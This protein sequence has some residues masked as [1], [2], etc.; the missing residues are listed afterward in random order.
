MYEVS[1]ENH[2]GEKIDLSASSSYD[3]LKID[4]LSP[5]PAT[6]NFSTMANFDGGKFN[7]GQ[8]QTRNIVFTIKI[9]PD[10]EENRI[11]L[12]KYFPS[13][14]SVRIYYRNDRRDVYID[15]IVEAVEIDPFSINETAQISIICPD[16]YW[17]ESTESRLNFSNVINLFEFPFSIP[18][19]GI[20][21]SK[22]QKLTTVFFN[23]GEVETGITIEFQATASQILNPRFINR[24]TQEYF[25]VD[26]DM[27]EGDLIR[28]NT[29]RGEKSAILIHDGTETNIIGNRQTGSTWVQLVAGVNELSYECDN[30]AQNLIVRVY[31]HILYGG[32]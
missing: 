1:V 6:L 23:N 10:V 18:A 30:G 20:E 4:G 28:I 3:V 15:G 25:G 21:F 31:T 19:A 29:R 9:Y 5:P 32:V 13:K 12:Y 8:L 16:P 11:G 7:S 2:L 27:T 22:I 26:I 17:K 24:T 14:K